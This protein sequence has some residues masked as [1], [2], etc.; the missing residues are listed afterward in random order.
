MWGRTACAAAVRSSLLRFRRV[1][2]QTHLW[3]AHVARAL[4]VRFH[5]SWNMVHKI[6]KAVRPIAEELERRQLLSSSV[7]G[8]SIF[9][10]N[11]TFDGNNASVNSS[12]DAAV[13]SDKQALLPGDTATFENYTSYSKGINGIIVDVSG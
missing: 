11:S 5:G 10:N 12:D 4:S 7:V 1:V 3:R 8:E 2:M 13:A 6:R 9:Y